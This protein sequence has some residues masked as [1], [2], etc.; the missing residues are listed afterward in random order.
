MGA[1]HAHALYVHEHS[2]LHHIAPEAKIVATVGI[3]ICVAITPREAIWAFGVYALMIACLVAVSRVPPLFV[4]T[5]LTAVAPFVIFALFIPFIGAGETT[6][7]LG[8]TLSVDGLWA[9]WNILAKAV[10]GASVSIVLTATTEV[11]DI[12]KGLAVLRVSATLTA[13]MMF[14]V[15]YLELISDELGRMR[16]AMTARGY[17]PRWL[18][19]AR[20]IATSAGALFVRSYERGERVHGAMLARGFTGVMPVLEHHRATGLAWAGTAAIVAVSAA[21]ATAALIGS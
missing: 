14:M 1:G 8:L 2:P 17:D 10:L 18:S 5:R 13:I 15:R 7:V 19:Q 6:Q 11:A 12:M 16:V 9:T 21:I 4:L 20:P 3:V